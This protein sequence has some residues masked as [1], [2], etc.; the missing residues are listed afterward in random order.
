MTEPWATI[1]AVII[2]LAVLAGVFYIIR[3]IF[4]LPGNLVRGFDKVARER[5]EEEHE[6][7]LAAGFTPEEIAAVDAKQEK[8]NSR[9]K[10]VIFGALTVVGMIF[11]SIVAFVLLGP[12]ALIIVIPKWAWYLKW[13]VGKLNSSEA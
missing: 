13:A 9:V 12:F 2:V 10:G 8:V 1:F 7:A 3:E 6:A 11:L 5:R 4:R